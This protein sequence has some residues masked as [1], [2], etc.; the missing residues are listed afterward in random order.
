M[1]A[2]H[3]K[4]FADKDLELT[5]EMRDQVA[6]VGFGFLVECFVEHRVTDGEIELFAKWVGFGLEDGSWGAM[7]EWYHEVPQLVR[8]Y[9]KTVDDVEERED[10]LAVLKALE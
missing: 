9:V 10:M 5:V 3:L 2:M 4:R 1:S 7:E 6:F 8:R